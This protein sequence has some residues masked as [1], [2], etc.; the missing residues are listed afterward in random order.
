MS[1]AGTRPTIAT[2]AEDNAEAGP[3]FFSVVGYRAVRIARQPRPGWARLRDVRRSASTDSANAALGRAMWRNR[4]F[5]NRFGSVLRVDEGGGSLGLV[6]IVTPRFHG[7][8]C[9][10]QI[11]KRTSSLNTRELRALI[12]PAL[13][14]T[15]A[16][17]A[18]WLVVAE[19]LWR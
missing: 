13:L 10:M 11:A 17:A 9:T 6:V 12:G 14:V 18:V 8:A 16:F 19:P 15:A 4:D 7:H 2:A 3:M 1:S 5:A